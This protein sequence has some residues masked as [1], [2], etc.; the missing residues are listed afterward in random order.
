MILAFM[1]ENLLFKKKIKSLNSKIQFSKPEIRTEKPLTFDISEPYAYGKSLSI[2]R[3]TD[4]QPVRSISIDKIDI[5][6]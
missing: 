4:N 2:G 1:T 3:Q 5:V 6:V